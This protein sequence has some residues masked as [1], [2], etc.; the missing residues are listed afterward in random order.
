MI[1]LTA[2]KIFI[3]VSAVL[4]LFL[5][6]LTTLLF[7]FCSFDFGKDAANVGSKLTVIIDAGHGGE[8]GGAVADDGTTFEKDLNLDISERLCDMLR[9]AGVS[10]IMTRTEDI[11][12]YDREADYEGRKKV[13]DLKARLKISTDNPGAL[14][15]SIHMN[16]FPQKKYDGLQVYY[17]G[18]DNRSASLAKLIQSNTAS[19]LQKDNMRRAKGAG[20][21]IYLLDK[22]PNVAVLIECGFLSNDAECERLKSPDYRTELALVIFQSII[23]YAEAPDNNKTS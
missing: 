11:L 12:L 17:R 23:E 14:F 8:D 10:V 18:E 2:K 9:A 16:A 7:Y 1:F 22:N 6:M 19:L 21:S 13:L 4:L 3:S 15:V 20:S 5:F